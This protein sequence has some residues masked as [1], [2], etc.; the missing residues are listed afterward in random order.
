M[1][2]S[3]HKRKDV[4]MIK[5]VLGKTISD[6]SVFLQIEWIPLQKK[7]K[8][9]LC[10]RLPLLWA[11]KNVGRVWHPGP[12]GF[13]FFSFTLFYFTILYLFCHTSTWSHHG[14]TWVPNPEP[15]SHLPPHIISLGHPRAPAPSILYPAS[16]IDWRFVTYILYMFQCHSPKSSHPLLLPQ[17]PKSALHICVSFAVSH[18][19]SSLPSF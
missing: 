17:S 2:P 6:Q 1:L 11:Q 3:F 19:G 5:Y 4:L 14:C 18:T 9:P 16:N 7:K 15:P 10:L 8:R 13:F 12:T